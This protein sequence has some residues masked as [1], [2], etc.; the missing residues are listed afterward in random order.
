MADKV[1]VKPSKPRTCSQQTQ[2]DNPDVDAAEDP[3]AAYYRVALTIPLLDY[4][5]V[6]FSSRYAYFKKKKL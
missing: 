4:L 5:L 2:R 6:E 1:Q 3:I